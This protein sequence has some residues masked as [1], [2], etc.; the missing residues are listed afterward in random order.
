MTVSA[1]LQRRTFDG[2]MSG[3]RGNPTQIDVGSGILCG[4]YQRAGEQCFALGC[5]VGHQR[6]S[7][8]AYAWMRLCTWKYG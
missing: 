1:Y 2:G 4:V 3:E 8:W 6:G 7:C 5:P